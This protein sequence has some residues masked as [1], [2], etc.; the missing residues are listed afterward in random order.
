MFLIQNVQKSF[1]MSLTIKVKSATNLPN[2]DR[3]SAS[4]PFTILIFQGE[5]FVRVQ[6]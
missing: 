5:S 4:D 3:F 1:K 6:G 2:V